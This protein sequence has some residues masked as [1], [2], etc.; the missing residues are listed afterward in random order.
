MIK[1]V[2]EA[3]ELVALSGKETYNSRHPMH[4]RHPVLCQP[5]GNL[6]RTAWMHP[7]VS[8]NIAHAHQNMPDV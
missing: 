4:F 2:F 8:N 1:G 6:R 3:L 5:P 7:R